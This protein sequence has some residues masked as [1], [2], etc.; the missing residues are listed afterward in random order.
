M[1]YYLEAVKKYA[2]FS[3]RA[4]RKEYW[5]YI[6]FNAI[7]AIVA[8]IVDSI[9]GTSG[10]IAGIYELAFLIPTLAVGVRRLHDLGK[11]G[12]W[13]F[14]SLVPVIGGIWFI[15][16]MCLDG[17]PGENQYGSNPKE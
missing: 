12:F 4:R 2:T 3:G 6:L 5:M 9:I 1:N 15:V 17:Q 14:I 8:T 13:Y 7:F 10:I 11:S 16:L